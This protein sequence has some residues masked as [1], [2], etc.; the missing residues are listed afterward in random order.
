MAV[1]LGFNSRCQGNRS[2]EVGSCPKMATKDLFDSVEPE[3]KEVMKRGGNLESKVGSVH[4]RRK[5]IWYEVRLH[6]WTVP[7]IPLL[8]AL[9]YRWKIN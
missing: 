4:I 7:I 5:R 2:R 8:Y 3:A 6:A 1:S 9:L